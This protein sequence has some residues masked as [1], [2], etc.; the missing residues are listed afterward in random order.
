MPSEMRSVRAGVAHSCHDVLTQ[1][2]EA[3][4]AILFALLGFAARRLP[5][6]WAMGLAGAVQ[7]L[8]MVSPLGMRARQV[9][10]ATF[11]A[12]RDVAIAARWIGRPFRDHVVAARIASKREKTSDWTVEM[13]GAPAFLDDPTQSFII[14]T[15][16]FSR[17]AM[18]ALYLPQV[19]RRRLATIVAPMTQTK[20][21]LGVRVR[22]Q[23]REMRRGIEV[24]RDGDVDIADVAG[25]SFLVRLLH[26]LRDPGGA[27][28]IATDAAWGSHHTGGYTRPFAGF[29]SQTFALGTARL[30]R[31]S[32]CPI[33]T[34]VPFVDGD[35]RVILDWGPVIPAPARGDSE[36]DIRITNEILDWIERRIGERPD[37]YVLTFGQGR[38]WSSV[39]QCW[40]GGKDVLPAIP[41]TQ[42]ALSTV[43]SE[44]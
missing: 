38:Y 16:H 30:A 31:L 12:Q 26:H 14:A 44:S 23:M 17:E 29:A 8:L 1:A 25:K 21:A 7:S 28:I 13:R 40:V 6:S 11:P 35:Q 33:V 39:A 3:F 19:I 42:P 4:R 20:D 9:V 24:V 37:Q 2:M 15:G 27:V 41:K 32:Q 43:K 10:R 5:R 18:T 34:C 36:A 22:L